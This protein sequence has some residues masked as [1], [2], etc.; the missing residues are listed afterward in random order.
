MIRASLALRRA[1]L[2]S[3]RR[4]RP[5]ASLSASGGAVNFAGVR[6]LRL[7]RLPSASCVRSYASDGAPPP[8]APKKKYWMPKLG[9]SQRPAPPPA[10]AGPPAPP[11]DVVHSNLPPPPSPLNVG[12]PEGRSHLPTPIGP[13]IPPPFPSGLVGAVLPDSQSTGLVLHHPALIVTRRLEWGNIIAGF[14]QA[15]KYDIRNESGHVI[16]YMAEEGGFARAV[17]RNVLKTHRDARI[18]VFDAHGSVVF[19]VRRPFYIASSSL[20][21]EDPQGNLVGEVHEQL[22]LLRR[23]YELFWGKTQFGKIDAPTLAWEFDVVDEHGHKVAAVDKN[24]TG[25]AREL[26]TDGNQYIVRMDPSRFE[27]PPPP[28]PDRAAALAAASAPAAAPGAGAASTSLVP[29]RPPPARGPLNLDKRAVILATA[30]TIDFDY[31]SKTSGGP[32]MMPWLMPIPI[33]GGGGGGGAPIPTPV[34]TPDLEP[35][36]KPPGPGPEA[37]GAQ[38]DGG[39]PADPEAFPQEPVFEDPWGEDGGEGGGAGGGG[40]DEEGGRGLLGTLWD[41]FGGDD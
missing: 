11:P 16:G 15:N 9:V 17:A 3:L 12:P 20:Y 35:G 40:G 10:A 32:G 21:V 24:F 5:A 34:P 41:I 7:G 18:T 28:P 4:L 30:I 19:V 29:V 8:E 22:T 31:F 6:A 27:E 37:P 25:W 26:F 23:K 39:V 1:A 2:S 36:Q 33:P 13:F 38:P 14:E